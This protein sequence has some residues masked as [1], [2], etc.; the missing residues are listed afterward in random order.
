VIVAAPLLAD[1]DVV[2]LLDWA[3]GEFGAGL[4]VA[5][6]LSV[7]DCLIVHFVAELAQK[8]GVAPTVFVLDTGRLHEE[9]HQTLER[10]RDRYA[11]PFHVYT[12]RSEAVEALLTLHG[13]LSFR[14]SVESRQHCC[15][16][17]KV[18]PLSRALL[19]A[20]AWV[21]GLRRVHS[22]SRATVER[23][24]VDD[25]HGRVKLSPL[26]HLGDDAL[27]ALVERHHTI[28]H[29]LHRQGFP[30]IGCAPCTRAIAP[31]EDLRAGRWWWEDPAH[32]ECGLHRRPG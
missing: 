5:C 1:D 2:G 7:E 16:I 15:A 18:E 30:S 32:S 17:R 3:I 4:R 27:W 22:S 25:G 24:E 20:R 11:L 23:I 28:V 14:R 8:H 29:P 26:A 9:T 10:L 6:S 31:G 19:G 21:T 12:P 13:P